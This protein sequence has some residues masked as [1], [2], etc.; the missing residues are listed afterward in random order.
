MQRRQTA[1][2]RDDD[3]PPAPPRPIEIVGAVFAFLTTAKDGPDIVR[4]TG[5]PRLVPE[6]VG[7]LID[8]AGFTQDTALFWLYFVV[9]YTVFRRIIRRPQFVQQSP[10]GD[11]ARFELAMAGLKRARYMKVIRTFGFVLLREWVLGKLGVVDYGTFLRSRQSWAPAPERF[12]YVDRIYLNDERGEEFQYLRGH[13]YV[14][15]RCYK[16]SKDGKYGPEEIRPPTLR[17]IKLLLVA[18]NFF[19]W[20]FIIHGLK[21]FYDFSRGGLSRT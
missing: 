17:E 7:R 2:Q 5:I 14:A 19:P 12:D 9:C 8:S 20:W 10:I 13:R 3:L 1:I 16:D 15:Y 11:D 4:L 6:W 18:S 21:R